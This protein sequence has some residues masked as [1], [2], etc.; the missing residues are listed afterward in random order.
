MKMVRICFVALLAVALV[1]PLVGCAQVV[2]A[3]NW[4]LGGEDA[5]G[6]PTPGAVQAVSG[7]SDLIVPGSSIVLTALGGLWAAIRGRK[8]KKA[9]ES[10][11]TV[12]EGASK[13]KR[14]INE[15]KRE[16]KEAHKA[17]GVS[18]LVKA[19]VDKYGHAKA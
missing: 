3:L 9:F 18:G 16:L 6:N 4:L 1:M 14:P 5:Q 15:L 7:F 10:T 12:I 17:A 8:W 11:A 19:V 13:A 2:S